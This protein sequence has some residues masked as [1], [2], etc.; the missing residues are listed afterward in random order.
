MNKLKVILSLITRDNDYQREQAKSAEA[1][2]LQHDVD[3]EVVYADNDSVTQS[4]QLLALMHK[5][6][7]ELKGILVEPAGGT[8][9]PQVG[10]AAVRAGI[11][12]GV[13]N[14]DASC[15]AELRRNSQVPAFVV[16]TD[17][18]Q[19]GRIQA[20]QLAAILPHG[21]T[22]LCIQGPSSSVVAHHRLAGLETAKPPNLSIKLLKSSN[23]TEEGGFHAVSSWLRLS[24][25]RLQPIS[26]VAA[27]NDFIAVG[28]RKAFEDEKLLAS[29]GPWSHLPFLG[30]DGLPR[31]GQ[32]FVNGGSMCATVVTPTVAGPAL[33]D[34]VK[35]IQRG[36]ELPD[37]RLIPSQSYPAIAS[38]RPV[39]LATH[40]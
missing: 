10:A 23:W 31:T 17:H 6:K 9:F 4:S 24:T 11:A 28:A 33:E 22:V 18:K 14:R 25:S 30:V 26:A 15:V 16:S 13:L 7:S 36:I 5:Y 37:L 27:Q 39:A 34:L 12:W 21:G 38:L 19:V 2:A 32:A 40:N 29:N 35:A 1:V 8:A 3:L 20:Q